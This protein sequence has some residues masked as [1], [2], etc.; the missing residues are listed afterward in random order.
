MSA[1]VGGI[2]CFAG[3]MWGLRGMH[4]AYIVLYTPK[5]SPK[6]PPVPAPSFSSGVPTGTLGH[7]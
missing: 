1:L 3:G 2:W 5:Q 4:I 7:I 6:R